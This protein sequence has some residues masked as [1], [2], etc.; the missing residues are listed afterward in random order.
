VSILH[1]TTNVDVG[2]RGGVTAAK[3]QDK[4]RKDQEGPENFLDPVFLVMMM[5]IT[6]TP[7]ARNKWCGVSRLSC[8]L[9]QRRCG[10]WPWLRRVI[11][12][13]YSKL[14]KYATWYLVTSIFF[15]LTHILRFWVNYND[16]TLQPHQNDSK[17]NY[18]HC[19]P[20]FRLVKYY[21]LPSVLEKP[22]NEVV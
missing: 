3:H 4:N 16:L 7:P 17:D 5:M 10:G 19:G 1:K 2:K 6:V 11:V 20:Y 15:G 12:I 18:P 8:S 21:N 14:Q 9:A 22:D 13:T